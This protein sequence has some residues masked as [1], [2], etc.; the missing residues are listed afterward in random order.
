MRR[1]VLIVEDDPEFREM[2]A[3][4]LELEGF[5][6]ITVGNCIKAFSLFYTQHP[7]VVVTDLGLPDL[8]GFELIRWA[9]E[10]KEFADLPI[11]AI[12]AY[13]KTYLRAALANGA[14][15][16]LDKTDDLDHLVHVLDKVA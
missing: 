6:V 3:K 1:K 8:S 12:S 15:E 9:R 5:N 14:T 11:V 13:G 7:N 4:L 2:L 10:K 16:A